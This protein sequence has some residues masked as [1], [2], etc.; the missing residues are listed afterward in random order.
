L[1]QAEIR[2]SSI[3]LDERP[4]RGRPVTTDP[5]AVGLTALRLFAQRGI[6]KVTMDD[7]AEAAS[8][9]RS[10]LFRIFP[11][12][13]AVVWGGMH[14]FT[15]ELEK[16]I[17]ENPE[18]DIVK[19]LHASWVQAMAPLDQRIET[20]RLRLKLIAGSPEIY[21]WGQA[22]M[23][24]TRQVIERAV[25]KFS[26]DTLRPKIVSAA[27]ISASMAILIWWAET[28]DKRTPSEVLDQG[29]KDFEKLFS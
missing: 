24:E 6:D 8:I 13:A 18:T 16:R 14:E 25:S 28:G 19:L 26:S 2:D 22:Q 9:S 10:N 1:R 5:A 12:K 15:L 3:A 7:V 11:S 20:V 17:S 23:E 4:K 21:G 29:F 27:L